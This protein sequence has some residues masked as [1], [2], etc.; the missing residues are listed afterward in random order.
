MSKNKENNNSFFDKFNK[1]TNTVVALYGFL[2]F[3][4]TVGIGGYISYEGILDSISE[5]TERIEITQMMILKDIVR[6]SEHNPCAVSDTE[7]DEY[8][9]NYS[10]LQSLKKKYKKISTNA[11]WEPIER[12]MEDT[13]QCKRY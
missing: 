7:W 12:L 13:E 11:K 10:I 3:V 4:I 8:L 9:E 6:R 2:S 1:M 5:N